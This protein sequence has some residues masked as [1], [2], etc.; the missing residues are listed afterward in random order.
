VFRRKTTDTRQRKFERATARVIA[1]QM[2]SLAV[3]AAR[4]RRQLQ[5]ARLIHAENERPEACQDEKPD[6]AGWAA[7]GE[8]E[9]NAGYMMQACAHSCTRCA[10]GPSG[11]GVMRSKKE[12]AGRR[13]TACDNLDDDCEARV[14][15]GACHDGSDAPLR[16]PAGCRICRFP[17]VAK[18]AYGC[19]GGSLFGSLTGCER[20][21]LRCA[22]PQHT[23]PL[24]TPG[25]IDVTMR[26]ILTDFPQYSPRAIS[27]P[28]EGAHGDGE[29]VAPWV[30]TLQD[31]L[32]DEEV[33]AFISGC[34]ALTL[35][36]PP[37]PSPAQTLT[38][39]P[40]ARS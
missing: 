14:A 2:L 10:E 37:G 32:S 5:F 33:A 15:A 9:A 19:S 12:R 35:T 20:R 29:R 26:R 7:D 3:L 40:T 21:R 8:C 13:D 34:R 25:D 17:E 16:C 36:L 6:C 22:R 28:G 23:P 31:F 27:R 11:V 24:V 39:D 4:P 18:E 30:I 1:W 38:L